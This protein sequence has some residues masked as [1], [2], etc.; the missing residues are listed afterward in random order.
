MLGDPEVQ[1]KPS[2]GR[3][4]GISACRSDPWVLAAGQGLS[5]CHSMCATLVTA[6]RLCPRELT[7]TAPPLRFVLQRKGSAAFIV[8]L[9]RPNSSSSFKRKQSLQCAGGLQFRPGLPEPPRKEQSSAGYMANQVY[10]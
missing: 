8:E 3:S 5:Q 9:Q 2:Q 6:A 10:Y 7:G 4:R 1:L